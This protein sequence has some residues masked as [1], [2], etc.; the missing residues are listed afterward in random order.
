MAQSNEQGAEGLVLEGSSPAR[1]I[2]SGV[3]LRL[4]RLALAL[5]LLMP[6]EMA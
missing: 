3:T 4:Q 5:G 1:G 2:V 6:F